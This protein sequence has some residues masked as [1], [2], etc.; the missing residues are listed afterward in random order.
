MQKLNQIQKFAVLQEGT[1]ATFVQPEGQTDQSR[2]IKMRLNAPQPVNLFITPI[3]IDG[4]TGEV[5]NH[6]PDDQIFLAHVEAGF[7]T[8]EFHYHGSFC[9][10]AIGGDIWLDTYDNTSFS[11]EASDPTSFARLF[12]REERHPAILEMERMARHNQEAMRRQ[13]QRD[14]DAAIAAMEARMQQN[15]TPATTPIAG[16]TTGGNGDAT[17]PVPS[18]AGAINP[19][20]DASA[21]AGTGGQPA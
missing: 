15:V 13:N 17:A 12:E 3:D 20:P 21:A 19:Q 18:S 5:V 9:L 6:Y 2:L 8:I 11:V 4:E 16:G 14:M 10:N 7:E 1:D